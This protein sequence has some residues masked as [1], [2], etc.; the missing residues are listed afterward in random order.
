MYP[1][2][3]YK[4]LLGLPGLSDALLTNHFTLYEG[5]VNNT[6]KLTEKLK[7]MLASD[8]AATPEYAELKR[9]F[10]WEYNGM[11][12][13]EYYFENLTQDAENLAIESA[14]SAKIVD[15]FGSLEQ[16]EKD[17]RATGAM[18]GIGWV[19]LTYDKSL[20]RLVN[21]WIGEHDGGH[22]AGSQPLLVMDVFEH[23]FMLD[24]GI[25]RADYINAF[26]Q[27]IRWSIVEKRYD[28]AVQYQEL[29]G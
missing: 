13:H 10:G 11:V 26:F 14:L 12:L 16:W 1:I 7:D 29:Q 5:Y 8:Q 9:R 22:L 23:A 24:Y 4:H 6:N 3:D 15:D 18:R 28:L 17:F 19:I 2:Q 27:S 20:G 21:S 25:K